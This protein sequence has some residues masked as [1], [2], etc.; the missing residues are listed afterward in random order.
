[1]E[2]EMESNLQRFLGGS[3]G[4]VATKLI[5]LSL[6]V[7]AFMALLG[8]TPV[9]LFERVLRLL[10]DIA[11]LGFGSLREVGQW[12]LYGAMVVVPLWLLSRLF[13]SRR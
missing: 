6:L 12:L 8:I 7:G 3:P 2:R 13:A 5:F 10:R 9:G 1:M 4:A 11:D